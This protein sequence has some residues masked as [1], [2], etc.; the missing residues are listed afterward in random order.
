MMHTKDEALLAL[1]TEKRRSVRG[2][3]ALKRRYITSLK[4]L[5]FY[6]DFCLARYAMWRELRRRQKA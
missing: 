4:D 5:N 1:G 6:I 3:H 2:K